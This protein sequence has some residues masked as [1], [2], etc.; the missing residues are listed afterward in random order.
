MESGASCEPSKSSP[1]LFGILVVAILF[2]LFVVP[3]GPMSGGGI[4]KAR[5]SAGMQ[6]AHAIGLALY[7]YASDN[8]QKYPD[9]A[10]STEV[11]QKLMDGGYVTDPEVFYIPM[12]GK[13]KPV[14]GAKLKPE[15]ISWDV[16]AP[17]E[18]SAAS[19]NLPVLFMTGYHIDY[20][21][22]GAATPIIKPFPR[23]WLDDSAQSWFTAMLGDSYRYR[24]SQGLAVFYDNNS[25]AF[26]PV[27][28]GGYVISN[29]VPL[30]FTPDG[31]TYRQLTPDGVLR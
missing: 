15:N 19:K 16:T 8:D 5:Q 29:F 14:A 4:R 7:S 28:A 1:W 25:A 27:D 31:K 24:P 20:H 18:L 26:H 22:G 11:F 21:P 3:L 9:G 17:V 6:T 12:P 30:D 23:Y 13:T 2:I 10:S